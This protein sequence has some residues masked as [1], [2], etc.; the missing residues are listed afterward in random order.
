MHTFLV[1]NTLVQH[2]YKREFSLRAKYT[3]KNVKIATTT[4]NLLHTLSLVHTHTTLSL[5][6]SLSSLF[7]STTSTC[8]NFKYMS[9]QD[10]QIVTATPH[11]ITPR[12]SLTTSSSPT[13]TPA[14]TSPPTTPPSSSFD[15]NSSHRSCLTSSNSACK[16]QSCRNT[17]DSFPLSFLLQ[18]HHCLLLHCLQTCNLRLL[19]AGNTLTTSSL[20][21]SA[22]FCFLRVGEAGGR[23]RFFAG[24]AR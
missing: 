5:S 22:E 15:F 4:A 24:R 3:R 21:S 12:C 13:P 9:H 19:L 7:M 2:R 17:V 1:I 23:K 11:H 18:V 16:C 8:P 6:L 10:S 20:L 14:S